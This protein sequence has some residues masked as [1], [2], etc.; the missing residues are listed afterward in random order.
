MT[1]DPKTRAE[2]YEKLST[3]GKPHVGSE[4]LL[5]LIQRYQ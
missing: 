5:S 2:N 4:K 3:Y 1:M